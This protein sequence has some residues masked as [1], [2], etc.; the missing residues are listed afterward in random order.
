MRIGEQLDLFIESP[1]D[2]ADLGRMMVIRD[3][4]VKARHRGEPK[5]GTVPAVNAALEATGRESLG[6]GELAMGE[7]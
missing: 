2:G 6:P 1:T 5:A 4:Y 3:A 7:R